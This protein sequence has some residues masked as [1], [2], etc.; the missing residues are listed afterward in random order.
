MISQEI[1][2]YRYI[3]PTMVLQRLHIFIFLTGLHLLQNAKNG[4]DECK[5]WLQIRGLHVRLNIW[6]SKCLDLYLP[7]PAISKTSNRNR[8]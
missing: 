1:N 3:V 5:K 4:F 8:Q 6:T 7:K 2:I